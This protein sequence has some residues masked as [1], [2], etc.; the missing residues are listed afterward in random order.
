[1]KRYKGV[2]REMLDKIRSGDPITDRELS[3]MIDFLRELENM[4]SVMPPEYGLFLR[5]T[6]MN[7]NQLEDFERA[8]KRH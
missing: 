6:R 5:D 8:R 7:L 2:T 4:L 1:M 3:V